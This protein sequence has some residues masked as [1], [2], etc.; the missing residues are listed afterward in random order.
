MTLENHPFSI[1]S[2]HLHP[3]WIFHQVMWCF[4]GGG[5]DEKIGDDRIQTFVMVDEY[6]GLS[7]GPQSVS[8]FFQKA[9]SCS[10]FLTAATLKYNFLRMFFNFMLSYGYRPFKIVDLI[11]A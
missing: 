3:W 7:S 8:H 5:V 2:I 10:T 6:T 11:H 1:G 9:E 4:S